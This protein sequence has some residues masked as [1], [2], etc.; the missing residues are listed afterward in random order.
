MGTKIVGHGFY[1]PEN[2]VTNF[3][4]EKMMDTSNEWIV[5]RSGIHERRY[6]TP[7]G[8]ISTSDLAVFASQ[9]ALKM[10][11]L[12]AEDVDC[13]IAATLS[14]DY[15][16]PGIGVLIQA[17]LGCRTIPAFD[18]RQQCSGFIYGLQ[19]A[20]LFIKSGAYKTILFIGA[21]VQ[22]PGLD[23]TTRGRDISV[24]FGDGAGA[25]VLQNGSDDSDILGSK[26]YSD[27]R[28]Y[29]QLWLEYPVTKKTGRISCEDIEAGR[30]FGRM[31]GRNVFRY[32]VTRMP[33]VV[34]ELLKEHQLTPQD[35][36]MVIPH[37]A[38]Q[39]I[40]E[41]VAQRLGLPMEKVYSNIGKYGN[42]TAA[43]VPIAFHEA[44]E[45]GLIKR[46]DLVVTT[47]FGSGFTWGANLIRY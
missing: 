1:V 33:E 15:F 3:D 39:R 6:I 7:D 46:G 34:F 18:L 38:N 22:S 29:D 21:E 2:V 11:G 26:L 17:K 10:A 30:H 23:K 43:T 24:L 14:P 37:Q 20:D 32:A 8:D 36:A 9:K 4:L 13:I 42:T 19:M 25:F 27:G 16:F 31:N 45:A 28:F 5:E 47:S 40:T 12:Q 44:W 35:L 41:A